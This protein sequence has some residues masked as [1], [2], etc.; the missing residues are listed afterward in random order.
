MKTLARGREQVQLL[1]VSRAC[2]G[3]NVFDYIF[4]FSH[5]TS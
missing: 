1:Q 5:G 2:L 3:I 4:S